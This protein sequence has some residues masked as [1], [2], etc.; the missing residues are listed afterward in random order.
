MTAAGPSLCPSK[1]RRPPELPPDGV[2][3]PVKNPSPAVLN[4]T[5]RAKGNQAQVK[6][7]GPRYC[8]KKV[9]GTSNRKS[10]TSKLAN[11]R[12]ELQLGDD[13]AEATNALN[14]VWEKTATIEEVD[15]IQSVT[16]ASAEDDGQGVGLEMNEGMLTDYSSEEEDDTGG[17]SLAFQTAT[18]DESSAFSTGMEQG[19]HAIGSCK[20]TTT[21][22]AIFTNGEGL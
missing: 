8:V 14:D 20:G 11:G 18:N 9:S 3:P 12:F 6:K 7:L 10:I 13:D 17:G 19:L 16:K 15:T 21:S 5:R 4:R 2:S 1:H 22:S